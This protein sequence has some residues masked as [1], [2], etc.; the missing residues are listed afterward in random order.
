MSYHHYSLVPSGGLWAIEEGTCDASEYEARALR[1]RGHLPHPL[2]SPRC[3]QTR[4]PLARSST[5]RNVTQCQ[6][7]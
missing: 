1:S 2:S 4:A 7:A 5:M 6:L 3:A